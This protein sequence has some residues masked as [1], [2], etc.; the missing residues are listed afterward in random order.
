M[1]K[2][3]FWRQG[4]QKVKLWPN[5]DQ[6]IC[7]SEI[8]LDSSL[9]FF[10]FLDPRV[11]AGSIGIAFVRTYVRPYVRPSVRPSVNFSRKRLV[12]FFWFFAWSYR[13]I[14]GEKWQSR[15]FFEN[16]CC[17]RNGTERS[18]LDRKSGFSEISQERF[19]RFFLFFAWY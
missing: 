9:R 12:S 14:T 16:S 11:P 13:V 18:K 2:L 3:L 15:I 4:G 19:I 1:G 7:F 17:R 5:L 6:K 8:T 10:W